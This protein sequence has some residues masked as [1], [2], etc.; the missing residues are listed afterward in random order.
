V[1]AFVTAIGTG[2]TLAGLSR[3]LKS[4]NSFVNTVCVDPFGA[5]TW[6]WLK[7]GQ[8]NFDIGDSIP[9]GIGPGRVTNNA[10]LA[11]IDTAYR[12][13]DRHMMAII[14]HLTCEEGLFLG[15]LRG[16]M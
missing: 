5:A 6:S 3:Y 13:H 1:S 2:G 12:V 15:R 9:D 10:A 8:L 16:S 14:R 7:H 11:E 4:Q